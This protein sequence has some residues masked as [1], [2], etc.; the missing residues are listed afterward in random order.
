MVGVNAIDDVLAIKPATAMIG[1]VAQQCG[2]RLIM[3]AVTDE[4]PF[5]PGH[6][7][8][9]LRQGFEVK[10]QRRR[11][12]RDLLGNGMHDQAVVSGPN[13]QAKNT[14]AGFLRQRGKGGNDLGFIHSS[15]LLEL[16][17]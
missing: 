1:E 8:S 13:Q 4:A 9:R 7:E 5:V 11:R 12:C 17:K 2:H 10:G 16:W 3:G 15:I 14:Q 6:Y